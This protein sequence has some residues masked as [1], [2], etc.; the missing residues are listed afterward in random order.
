MLKPLYDRMIVRRVV[1]ESSGIIA[2]PESAKEKSQL[3]IVVAVGEGR[4]LD[5]GSMAEP[6]VEFADTILFGKYTGIE[7]E[8]GGEKLVVLRED[9]VLAIVKN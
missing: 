8:Y 4:L 2:I 3:G 6:R 7:I 1:E 9:E 5:N